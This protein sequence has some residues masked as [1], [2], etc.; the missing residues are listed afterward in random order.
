M[1]AE[2]LSIS[3]PVDM[4]QMIRRQ[5]E[6]EAYASV[7]AVIC[8]AVR[9]WQ[10]RA[11]EREKRLETLRVKINEAAENPERITDD[12]LQQRFAKRRAEAGKKRTP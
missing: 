3:L 9:L 11:H 5:V 2:K 4:A 12:E 7:R 10:D 8:D 6:G 1:Q